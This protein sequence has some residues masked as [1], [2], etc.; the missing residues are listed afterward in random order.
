T[1]SGI[2]DAMADY[3]RIFP[4][5]QS[6]DGVGDTS[7]Q[8]LA[9]NW[10]QLKKLKAKYPNLKV[11]ISLGGWTWSDGFYSAARPENRVAFVKSC[12]DA[13]IKGDLPVFTADSGG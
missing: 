12:I 13:Y 8:K 11:L 2:G 10:N 3:G 7:A 4:A 9:G 6:V 1:Q 5:D